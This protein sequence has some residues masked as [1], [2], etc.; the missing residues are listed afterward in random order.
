MQAAGLV[1]RLMQPEN[2]I[3]M[4]DENDFGPSNAV[5]ASVRRDGEKCRELVVRLG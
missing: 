2:F 4:L 3:V 5:V 1:D